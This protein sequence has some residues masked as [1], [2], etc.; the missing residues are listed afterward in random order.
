MTRPMHAQRGYGLLEAMVS[1]LVVSIGFLGFAGAQI[2]GLENA[3]NSLLRGKAVDLA[4][5]MTDRVRGNAPGAAAGAYNA[6]SG[7]MTM[8]ACMST[9]CTV[10]Q[11]AQ[12][13]YAEWSAA[14]AQVLPAGQAAVC[15]DSTPDD[16]DPGDPQCDNAGTTLV[17]KIWWQEKKDVHRFVN[18]FRP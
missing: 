15:L 7:A 2:K 4:Y 6:L 10:A 17:V 8:P 9:G 18:A 16:G 1:V 13:D 11:M 14:V 5:Q 3:N 12:G